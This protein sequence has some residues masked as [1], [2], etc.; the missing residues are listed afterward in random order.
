MV[1]EAVPVARVVFV[2]GV[3][4]L[5][6]SEAELTASVLPPFQALALTIEEEGVAAFHTGHFALAFFWGSSGFTRKE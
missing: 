5:A 1:I 2:V 3:P 6:K 4:V